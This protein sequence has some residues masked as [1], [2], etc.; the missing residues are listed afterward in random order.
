MRI[1]FVTEQF[2]YPLHD[3]GNLRTYHILRGLAQQHDVWLVAHEP[4]A[5]YTVPAFPKNFRHVTTVREPAVWKRTLWNLVRRGIRGNPLFLLKNWS[6]PLL[7]AVES[8]LSATILT[9]FISMRWIRLVFRC[10]EIGRS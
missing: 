2:P 7:Q 1:L 4:A 3:G 9:P 6:D 5:A 10:C 8:L